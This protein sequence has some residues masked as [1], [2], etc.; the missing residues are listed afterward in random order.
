MLDTMGNTY[1]P[2]LSNEMMRYLRVLNQWRLVIQLGKSTY[3]NGLKSLV[4]YNRLFRLHVGTKNDKK[5]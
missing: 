5:Y 4:V 1:R 2:P 3:P